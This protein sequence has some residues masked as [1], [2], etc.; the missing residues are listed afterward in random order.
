M[1]LLKVY[2]PFY[3]GEVL[4]PDWIPPHLIKIPK[5][6]AFANRLELRGRL[7]D[8][9]L[10]GTSRGE[11]GGKAELRK[12]RVLPEKEVI[13]AGNGKSGHETFAAPKTLGRLREVP[14][15]S[16]LLPEL[17]RE[18]KERL[19]ALVDPLHVLQ[20]EWGERLGYSAEHSVDKFI[21]FWSKW[22]YPVEKPDAGVVGWCQMPLAKS[23]SCRDC[24]LHGAMYNCPK[25]MTE[26]RASV[27][28]SCANVECLRFLCWEHMQCYCESRTVGQGG[29]AERERAKAREADS[30]K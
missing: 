1:L 19:F 20:C 21:K 17:Q 29:A 28:H 13:S 26:C 15:R 2:V 10:V 23:S 4:V 30:K 16:N 11:C 14:L 5:V 9:N 25:H 6:D 18:H 8:S 24:I 27:W 22:P 3:Q 7:P 12:P